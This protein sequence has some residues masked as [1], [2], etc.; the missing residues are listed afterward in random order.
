MS[1]SL[2][3][4]NTLAENVGAKDGITWKDIHSLQKKADEIHNDLV[5]KRKDGVLGFYDLPYEKNIIQIIKAISQVVRRK[6]EYFV[7]IGIG[8]S[9]L[10]TQVLCSSMLHSFHNVQN[11]RHMT[12]R[13][14]F[15]DNPD[16]R[17][18]IDLLDVINLNTTAFFVVSKSGNTDETLAILMI[19][20][21][22][23]LKRL[24]THAIGEHFV[25]A[26]SP[27]KNGALHSIAEKEKMRIL[28]LPDNVGGRFSALSAAGLYPAAVAGMNIERLLE[29]AARMDK[30]TQANKV[31]HN[32]AYLNAT[33]HYLLDTQKNKNISVMMPYCDSLWYFSRWYQQLWAESLGKAKGKGAVGQ[34]PLASLGTIDQHS[35][36]QLILDGPNDKT[37]TFIGRNRFKK[38]I[39]IPDVFRH[40]DSISYLRRQDLSKLMTS[41]MN[42]TEFILTRNNRPSVRLNLDELDEFNIGSLL[43]LYEVQTAFAGGLYGINAFDQPAVEDGKLVTRTLLGKEGVLPPHLKKH[44][45]KTFGEDRK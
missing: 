14:F 23:V 42:A 30:N 31:E 4:T 5:K 28:A 43:Y 11:K 20:F 8:G 22:R 7:H 33:V 2:E 10:G 18:V 32:P 19:L 26:T 37:V 12:P 40:E 25:V 9:C 1:V 34:T 15:M 6:F 41:E 36:L 38:D 16:P 17:T 29:G 45:K 24:G 35:L 21:S 3:I 13:F 44:F 27:Q 39:K